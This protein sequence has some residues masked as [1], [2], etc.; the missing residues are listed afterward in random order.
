MGESEDTT[1]AVAAARRHELSKGHHPLTNVEW[2]SGVGG[3]EE[4]EQPPHDCVHVKDGLPAILLPRGSVV[5]VDLE[6]VE[7]HLALQGNVGVVHLGGAEDHGG[8]VG[9]LGA[10]LDA[11][12][13]A[14]RLPQ[15]VIGG[16]IHHHVANVLLVRPRELDALVLLKLRYVWWGAGPGG[17]R[18]QGTEGGWQGWGWR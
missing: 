9:V 11:E 17:G 1:L 12:E 2:V 5:V 18:G 4:G 14:P 10:H 15:A 6:D 8:L 7:A 3:G 16:H 13:E